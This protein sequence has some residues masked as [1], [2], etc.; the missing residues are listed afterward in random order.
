MHV[1]EDK[2]F[3]QQNIFP[4]E[5]STVHF[6]VYMNNVYTKDIL[7]FVLVFSLFFIT[8]FGIRFHYTNSKLM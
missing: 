7:L 3:V 4:N 1:N 5:K 8:S 6:M 2:H